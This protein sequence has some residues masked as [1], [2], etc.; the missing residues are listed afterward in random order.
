[1]T[2]AGWR[3]LASDAIREVQESD[4]TVGA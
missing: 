4:V 3:L 1:M 2:G